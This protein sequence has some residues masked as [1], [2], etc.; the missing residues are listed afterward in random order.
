MVLAG[1]LTGTG[2]AQWGT[3]LPLA[4]VYSRPSRSLTALSTAP[5]LRGREE[6]K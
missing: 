4:R 6:D 1:P 5:D 2:P 3:T